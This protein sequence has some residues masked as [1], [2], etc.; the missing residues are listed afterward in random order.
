[1]DSREAVCVSSGP[2]VE[3][4]LTL[5]CFLWTISSSG[6]HSS[7][8]MSVSR[9]LGVV[10]VFLLHVHDWVCAPREHIDYLVPFLFLNGLHQQL[11]PPE[12]GLTQC[13]IW[14]RHTCWVPAMLCRAEKLEQRDVY[15]AQCWQSPVYSNN[16]CEICMDYYSDDRSWLLFKERDK[17]W[18]L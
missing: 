2:D 14:H 9:F 8:S 10:L 11:H 5:R 18:F 3:E 4:S 16:I 15:N 6:S 17:V 1:M 12:R 7:F 13:V